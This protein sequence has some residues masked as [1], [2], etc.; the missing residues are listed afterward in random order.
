MKPAPPVT[1]TLINIPLCCTFEDQ[2]IGIGP[3][4]LRKTS[5]GWNHD[6]TALLVENHLPQTQPMTL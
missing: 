6:K 3:I 2:F 4:D 5:G 1:T